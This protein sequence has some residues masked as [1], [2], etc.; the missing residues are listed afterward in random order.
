MSNI[1]TIITPSYNSLD[2]LRVL[3]NHLSKFNH[4]S[5][6]WLIVDSK[7]TD[8]T[9]EYINSISDKWIEFYTEKDRGI[10]DGLNKAISL[11][12]TKYY[13]VSGSDDLP[14]VDTILETIISKEHLNADLVLGKVIFNK[15]SIKEPVIDKI[16]V[17]KSRMSFH[18]VGSIIKTSIHDII[19]FYATSLTLASDELFFQNIINSNLF[20]IV[21]SDKIFG[22]YS[23]TG[24]SARNKYLATLEMFYVKHRT[25]KP[26]F[27]ILSKTFIKLICYKI[28]K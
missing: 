4:L 20:K 2:N 26:N 27:I 13:V 19:G 25:S 3:Y 14:F 6:V 5:F 7:S 12:R 10:Y 11:T 1:L 28:K 21:I 24:I 18:S 8:G 23:N 15:I 16:N 9:I 22:F 17:N